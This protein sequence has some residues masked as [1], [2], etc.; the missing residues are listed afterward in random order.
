MKTILVISCVFFLFSSTLGQVNSSLKSNHSKPKVNIT[1]IYFYQSPKC[2]LLADTLEALVV[3][4]KNQEFAKEYITLQKKGDKY[5][6]EYTVP[7][8][9]AVLLI[10]IV[11]AKIDFSEYSPFYGIKKKVTDNNNGNGFIVH[12]YD[13]K[14]N[15]FANEPIQEVEL[16]L[17]WGYYMDLITPS[18]KAIIEKYK[19]AYGRNPEQKKEN[20]YVDYL[21]IL[22]KEKKDAVREQLLNYAN[23]KGKNGIHESDFLNAAKVYGVLKMSVE[24]Q[25]IEDKI[26]QAYPFG[27]LAKQ[28]YWNRQFD[29]KSELKE[30]EQ[31]I[32]TDMSEYVSEFSDSSQNDFFYGKIVSLLFDIADWDGGLKYQELV[33]DKSM[34]AYLNNKYAK[35]IADPIIDNRG[36]NLEIAKMLSRKA[37]QYIKDKESTTAGKLEANIIGDYF[38]YLNTYALVLYK[39]NQYDSAF[40]YQDMMY[41]QGKVLNTEGLERYAVYAEKVKGLSFVKNF[42]EQQLLLGVNSAKMLTQLQSVYKQLNLPENEFTNLQKK[43]NVLAE[44]KNIAA[45][46][47]KLGTTTAKDFTLK[48][49]LG[50]DVTLSTYKGKVVILDFWATWCAPCK[51]SF[52]GMQELVNKHKEDTDVVF[53]F[54]DVLETKDPQKVREMVRSYVKDNNYS[55]NV[56]FDE[57]NQVVKDYKVVAIPHKF[58]ID[59]KGSVV[60]ISDDINYLDDISLV[61]DGAKNNENYP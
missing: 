22:Y 23:E 12:L 51:A 46:K 38:L 40:Y 37:L 20:N 14:G 13:S 41:H 1:N 52:P 48:N 27:Q 8:S 16:L 3:F 39:L 53:L 34:N 45:I 15:P 6:F 19:L 58:V 47:K 50:N 44:Q 59:K 17:Y 2:L 5:S 9:V 30:T 11:D 54:V 55:F 25:E 28:K 61:I 57:K 60:F 35:K 42:L 36:N 21:N 7:D 4:K 31:S 10:A 26:L 29:H 56:L 49:L 24:K 32:L 33:Y 43:N 18:N